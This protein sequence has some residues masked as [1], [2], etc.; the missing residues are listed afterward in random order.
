MIDNWDQATTRSLFLI[1]FLV[2][3]LREEPQEAVVEAPLAFPLPFLRAIWIAGFVWIPEIRSR[4]DGVCP[5]RRLEL[6]DVIWDVR[7]TAPRT[8]L[9]DLFL[10]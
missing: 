1:R 4:F 7:P 9:T 10:P 6:R 8:M 5:A 3:K 2:A